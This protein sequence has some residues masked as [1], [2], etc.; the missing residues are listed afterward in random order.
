MTWG[1]AAFGCL[2]G[3]GT[4]GSRPW[5]T[6]GSCPVETATSAIL[7]QPTAKRLPCQALELGH[8]HSQH[9]NL[10]KSSSLT[11][12]RLWPAPSQQVILIHLSN[13]TGLKDEYS[14]RTMRLL[15]SDIGTIVWGATSAMAVGYVKVRWRRQ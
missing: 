9:N 8:K 7:P 3:L 10:A 11:L 13:L 5:Q 1:Q 2:L 4:K 14:K 6:A 15:V 12:P